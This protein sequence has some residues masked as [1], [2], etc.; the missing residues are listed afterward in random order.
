MLFLKP[1]CVDRD[2]YVEKNLQLRSLN[3]PTTETCLDLEIKP[4]FNT[5]HVFLNFHLTF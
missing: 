4:E 2:I 1:P 5:F 3:V